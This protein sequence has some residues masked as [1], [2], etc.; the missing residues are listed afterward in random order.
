VPAFSDLKVLYDNNNQDK[1]F[2]FL[3]DVFR[4]EGR[5]QIS[6]FKNSRYTQLNPRVIT[7]IRT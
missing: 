2:L 7:R 3:T 6:V 5:W 4:S 1:M